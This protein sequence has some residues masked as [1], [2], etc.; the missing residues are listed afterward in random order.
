MQGTAEAAEAA[1]LV[2]VNAQVSLLAGPARMVR[3]LRE[4]R[5]IVSN[6][7]QRD[8]RLKYRDSAFGFFWSLLEPLLL[9]AVYFALFVIV[10]GTPERKVPLWIIVGVITWSLFSTTLTSSLS[11]LTKNEGIIK[12]VYFPREI[13]AITSAGSQLVLATLSLLVAIPFMIYFGIVPSVYLLMVPLGLLL[14]ASLALGIGLGLACLNVVNRDVEHLFKFVTRAGM[15]L[16][17][18]MWTI[19]LP[20]ARSGA[21][22]FLFYN[23]M[24]APLTMVRNGIDGR[25]LGI[26]P[27]YVIYSVAFCLIALVLG[28]MVF[29]RHEALVVKKL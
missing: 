10:A 7:I 24:V 2:E 3:N 19:D 29:K 25:P 28:A 15:F 27:G 16:S 22:E 8:L 23:P 4:H 6:F 1:E 13:F 20:R 21:L 14:S 17:P 26:E 5:H 9:S 12:Q 11:C 18:V